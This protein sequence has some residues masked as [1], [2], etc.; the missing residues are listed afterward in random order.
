MLARHSRV[1]VINGL[2]DLLHPC[3]LLADIQT[4]VEHRG[5]IAGARVAWIGDAFIDNINSVGF[6]SL[7]GFPMT[8]APINLTPMM[9]PNGD[10]NTSGGNL[11]VS[12]DGARVFFIVDY[13]TDNLFEAWV[14]DSTGGN[15][16]PVRVSP[17]TIP[18]FGDVFRIY[19]Q[20]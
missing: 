14:G 6:S 16:N 11:H 8:P 4:Y 7:S 20:R 13:V 18:T 19:L 5:S 2:S 9:Q 10:A 3:Q 1:P 17:A 15:P 12:A